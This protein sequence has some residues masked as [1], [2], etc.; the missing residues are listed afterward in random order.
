M[1]SFDFITFFFLIAAVVIFLQLRSVLGSP[2]RQR[3]AT[4]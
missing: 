3:A 1:G 2:D 4:V